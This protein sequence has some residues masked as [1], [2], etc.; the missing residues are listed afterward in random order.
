VASLWWPALV[1]GLGKPPLSFQPSRP[2]AHTHAHTLH[3]PLPPARV[4]PS[5][6]RVLSPVTAG[7]ASTTAPA[8]TAG[9]AAAAP[10]A[11]V[12]VAVTCP[13]PTAALGPAVPLPA[14]RAPR[15]RHPLRCGAQGRTRRPGLGQQQA[16]L[17]HHHDG[18]AALAVRGRASRAPL[19]QY[20]AVVVGA[21]PK[22]R[23]GRHAQLAAPQHE[24]SGRVRRQHRSAQARLP[25][26]R[27]RLQHG[28]HG[29]PG[30]ALDP[31]PPPPFSPLAAAHPPGAPPASGGRARA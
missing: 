5:S 11:P 21:A 29:E 16:P 12:P 2:H 27:P 8:A 10:T 28:P 26:G 15:R 14:A 13:P 19:H 22:H 20:T 18:P 3:T 6:G 24:L 7:P 9:L 1:N 30:R 31:T 4:P 25:L 23:Q 17:V